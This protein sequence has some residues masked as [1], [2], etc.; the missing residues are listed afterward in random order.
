M[1]LAYQCMKDYHQALIKNEECLKEIE[2]N[3]GNEH[4]LYTL[5]LANMGSI[6]N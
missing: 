3:F 4:S 6:Y 2:T 5:V 1:A